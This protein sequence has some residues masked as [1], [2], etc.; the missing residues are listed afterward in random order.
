MVYI[1]GTDVIGIQTISSEVPTG[2]QLMQNYPNPFNPT[3]KIRFALPVS[4]FASLKV[5]DATGKEVATLVSQN[6]TAGTFEYELKGNN[7][8]SGVYFYKL[9]AGNFVQTKKMVLVK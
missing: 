6:L 3:T 2:F 7:L 1:K 5:Y 9:A 8:P 4:G